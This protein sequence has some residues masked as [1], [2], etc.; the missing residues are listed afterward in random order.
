M[1][2]RDGVPDPS[3][4]AED[5][6][7]SDRLRK[8]GKRLDAHRDV[9]DEDVRREAAPARPG[10]AMAMRLAA[11]FVAGVVVGAALG[12]GFDR[13]FDTSPWGLV[14]LLLL[15]FAAGLL[16]VM[17]SAGLVRPGIGGPDQ[18]RNGNRDGT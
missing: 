7:L 11:D 13:L 5:T 14:V 1:S 18:G 4:S 15:G 2:D 3:T 16:N 12:W 6:E 9:R 8:L 17:R 10:V